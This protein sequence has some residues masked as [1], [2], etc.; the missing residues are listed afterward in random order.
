VRPV[1]IIPVALIGSVIFAL[2]SATAPVVRLL[3]F[4][5]GTALF[6]LFG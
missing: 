2:S 3:I 6:L 4:T 5:A 1:L